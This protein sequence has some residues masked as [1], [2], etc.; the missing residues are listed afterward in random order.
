MVAFPFNTWGY[1]FESGVNSIMMAFDQAD[2]AF[3]KRL[4]EL[5]TRLREVERAVNSGQ[6]IA[7]AEDDYPPET[8]LR[9][10][11]ESHA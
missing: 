10:R 3:A 1:E 8:Y 5:I 6:H 11:L 9:A 4:D 7:V 2:D